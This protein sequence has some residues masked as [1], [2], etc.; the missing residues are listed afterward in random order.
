MAKYTRRQELIENS[1]SY[2]IV[3]KRLCDCSQEERREYFRIRKQAS[4]KK[5]QI[6]EN[7]RQYRKKHWI[8]TK[9]KLQTESNDGRIE[10]KRF[11]KTN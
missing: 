9:N 8:E 4:R 5:E 3:G 1:L 7:E 10:W 11:Q 6:Q 2:N